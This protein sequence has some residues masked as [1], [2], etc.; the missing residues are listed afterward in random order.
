M[1]VA[2]DLSGISRQTKIL[3]VVSALGHEGKSTVAANLAFLIAKSRH[4]VLLIDCDLR[5]ASLTATM[6]AGAKAGLIELLGK[7]R[8]FNEVVYT[9]PETSLN[10]VP[11]VSKSRISNTSEVL[12]SPNMAT[13]LKLSAEH[14]D[15]I[16]L[17]LPPIASVVDVRAMGH[18]VDGFIY[19]VE[20][21][22]TSRETVFG[23]LQAT[24]IVR[25]KMIGIVLNKASEA[26]LQRYEKADGIYHFGYYLDDND[27]LKS[28]SRFSRRS[29]H[30]MK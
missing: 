2:V 19:V 1:K 27:D 8:P 7:S 15:Y 23:A 10:F 4:K 28:A 3:G 16:I 24:E 14:Y 11:A 30:A 9:D 21:G 25:E 29:A 17:D 5:N 20:W 13:F 6:T 18:L 12:S 26:A 22:R